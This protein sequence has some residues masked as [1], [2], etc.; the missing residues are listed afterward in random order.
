[1]NEELLSIVN[2]APLWCFGIALVLFV[3]IQCTLFLRLAKKEAA[4]INF[5]KEKLKASMKTGAIIAAGPALANIVAMFALMAC[6]G[7]PGGWM[8]LSVIGNAAVELGISTIV[9]ITQ[10]L[11]GPADPN[12]SLSVITMIFIM[13]ASVCVGWLLVVI[14][15]TPSMS[16]IRAKLIDKDKAWASILA[17]AAMVGL[18]SN[19]AAL[20]LELNPNV[21]M[22]ATVLSSFVLMFVLTKFVIPKHPRL[23]KYALTIVLALGVVV[24]G[25]LSSH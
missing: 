23:K 4:V 16:K 21:A 22:Y 11:N 15:V 10:G 9:S 24:G 2:S 17:S 6:I 8:R 13:M 19:L 7:S 18:F 1:M 12:I 3:L 25:L 20:Q 5:P 14:I